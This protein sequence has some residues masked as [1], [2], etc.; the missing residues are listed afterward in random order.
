MSS[1]NNT[2][3][4]SYKSKNLST[5]ASRV[6]FKAAKLGGISDWKWLIF[7]NIW[8]FFGKKFSRVLQQNSQVIFLLYVCTDDVRFKNGQFKNK[9]GFLRIFLKVTNFTV[10]QDFGVI[11]SS[12]INFFGRIF[13]M[14]VVI[15]WWTNLVLRTF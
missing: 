6:V 15:L 14:L 2:Y 1:T 5:V 11:T 3:R 13:D 4:Y 12:K 9:F 7:W 10:Y 8:W